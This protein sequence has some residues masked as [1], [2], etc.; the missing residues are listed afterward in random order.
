[1]EETISSVF[2]C[3]VFNRYGSREVGDMACSDGSDGDLRLSIWNQYLEVLDDRR[4]QTGVD[5]L[6]KIHVTTLNNYSM[7]FIRYDIGDVGVRGNDP[8]YIKKVEGRE[9]NML[10]AA[11]GKLVPAEF[12]IHFVGVVYNKGFISK[13]QVVQREADAIKIKVVLRDLDGFRKSKGDIEA[14]IRKVMGQIGIDWEDVADIPPLK[15][16]K[17]QYVVRQ[18]EGL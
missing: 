6:G 11:D 1:M 18:I 4:L 17:Y 3:P 13:F 9:M 16:G 15:S 2:G 8:L 5:D 7:P 14:T 12:F 10:R